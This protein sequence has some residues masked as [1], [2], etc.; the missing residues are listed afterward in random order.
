MNPDQHRALSHPLAFKLYELLR[1]REGPAP[2]T[3]RVAKILNVRL[4]Q[5]SRALHRLRNA[6]LV[7]Y[8]EIGRLRFWTIT[9]GT[10]QCPTHASSSSKNATTGLSGSTLNKS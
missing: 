5:A 8:K 6:N 2:N 1:S 7:T 10:P 4:D 9:K 3:T